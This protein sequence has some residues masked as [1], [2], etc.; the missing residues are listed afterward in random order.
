MTITTLYSTKEAAAYLE[1]PVATFKHAVWQGKKI[2]PDG[3]LGRNPYWT[4]ET[5]DNIKEGTE[6]LNVPP[7]VQ[8]LTAKDA[9]AEMGLSYHAFYNLSIPEDGQIGNTKFYWPATI[10]NYKQRR[11]Y[12]Y[13]TMEEAAEY[14]DLPWATLKHHLYTTRWLKP[15]NPEE[16][17][18]LFSQ[19][20]LDK[21]ATLYNSKRT[22]HTAN[23]GE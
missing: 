15:D 7:L 3:Y 19:E 12:P 5:L 21:F 2:T 8:P 6:N 4:Q 16:R 18:N 14:L 13:Y 11:H 20:T 10:E 23:P 17:V 9:A 1:M 22:L